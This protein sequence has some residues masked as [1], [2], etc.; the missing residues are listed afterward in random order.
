MDGPDFF[1]VITGI[2]SVFTFAVAFSRWASP[3]RRLGVIDELM[4][5]VCVLT[6]TIREE[7][8]FLDGGDIFMRHAQRR[9]YMCV[10]VHHT[11]V[12]L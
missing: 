1:G 3:H 10:F 4:G 8:R 9:V 7:D 12:S 2:L 5:K 11:R 6:A